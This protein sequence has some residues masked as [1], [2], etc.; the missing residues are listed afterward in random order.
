M[1]PENF[2]DHLSPQAFAD[3][4][5]KWS[6]EFPDD[7]I[8][9]DELHKRG[10]EIL[11][12]FA[13]L[14]KPL[15]GEEIAHEPTSIQVTNDEMRVLE[16]LHQSSNLGLGLRPHNPQGFLMYYSSAIETYVKIVPIAPY[17]WLHLVAVLVARVETAACR[18]IST[19]AN[20]SFV[21]TRFVRNIFL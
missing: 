3:L 17:A 20:P 13:L 2:P 10:F 15:A 1:P 12:L 21:T 8:S 14:S 16:Y 7:V 5:E 19:D 6:K 9:D 4:K 18:G 11:R